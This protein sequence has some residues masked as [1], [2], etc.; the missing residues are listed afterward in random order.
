MIAD[1]GVRVRL[2]IVGCQLGQR[3]PGFEEARVRPGNS[4]DRRLAVLGGHTERVGEGLLP[5]FGRRREHRL[6]K[7]PAERDG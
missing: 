6:G 7:A 3:R 1:P 4:R 5:I 2:H